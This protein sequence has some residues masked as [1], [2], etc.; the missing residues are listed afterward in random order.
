[1]KTVSAAGWAGTTFSTTKTFMLIIGFAALSLAL[2]EVPIVDSLLQ[3]LETFETAVHEMGH[4][5]ACIATGGSVD[6]LTIV[7]D[8][9]GHGGL[10]FCQG[11]WPFVYSQA[12]YIGEALFG[13]SL[14]LLSRFQ[15][16][17]RAI[18]VFIGVAIGL[19]SLM[20]MPG[21]I[22]HQGDWFAGLASMVWGLCIAAAFVLF[23]AKLPDK[24]AHLLLLFVAVQST[25]G[26]L[27]GIWVLLLQS[28]GLFP[29][30]WSDAT[31]MQKLT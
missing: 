13:C 10:T 24:W 2:K 4:A 8:G 25:L 20:L 30:S 9:A 18:L 21:T 15:R 27:S 6:G 5:L 14:I 23:G 1:M 19:G 16:L 26:S 29:G 11:G 17:S 22:F 31:N 3:P 12:G 7:N 28:F